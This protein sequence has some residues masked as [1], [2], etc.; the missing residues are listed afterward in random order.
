M[1]TIA[2]RSGVIAAD[3]LISYASI[4]NGQRE[5]IADCGRFAVA[6]AGAARL[7]RA[8]EKWCREFC[9]VDKVPQVLLDN[10]DSFSALI[11]DRLN[12]LVYEFDSGELTPVHAD[13]TAIG[14]GALLAIGAMAHGA[15]AEEAVLAA[16][17]HDKN[18]GGPVT[19]LS[20]QPQT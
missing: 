17:R 3:T 20:F 10:E 7:R 9:P 1:T 5:K 13:Y 19:S 11:V 16:S 14:S 4:T 6:L 18:T 8:L 15:T 12:G 2:I